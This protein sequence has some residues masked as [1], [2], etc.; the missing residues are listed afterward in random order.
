[1]Y[2]WNWKRACQSSQWNTVMQMI[3]RICQH[4]DTS[5]KSEEIHI[6][7][8]IILWIVKNKTSAPRLLLYISISLSFF[9]IKT[10]YLMWIRDGDQEVQKLYKT[11]NQFLHDETICMLI[12]TKYTRIHMITFLLTSIQE[13]SHVKDCFI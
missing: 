11:A 13:S 7:Y 12:I 9:L 8:E 4:Q 1:M 3:S 2:R 5:A 10:T 6:L